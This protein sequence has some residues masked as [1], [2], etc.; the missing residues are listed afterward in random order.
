MTSEVNSEQA[1]WWDAAAQGWVNAQDIV[2]VMLRPFQDLLVQA[3]VERPRD[4][5]LDV[6]CGTGD[7]TRAIAEA[8]GAACVGVDISGTMLAA[9]REHGKAE[10]VQADAQVHRFE[11]S[12]DLIVSRFGVMFFNDPAAA[13]RN[14][15]RAS[16]PGGQLCFIAWRTA[17]E[18]PFM[19]TATQAAAPL[20]P[21]APAPDPDGP[22]PFALADPD[23][24]RKILE[25]AGW[26]GI[27]IQPIDQIR[28]V[29]ESLLVPYLSNLG[30]IARAL[31]EAD[32]SD[33]PR[34]IASVRGAFDGFVHG[35]KVRIPGACWQVTARAL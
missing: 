9:A 23:K 21:D 28:S 10:F 19:T 30:P 4:R 16:A 5:V 18:N 8:T 1:A 24:T 15:L 33:R 3:A 12:F 34:I 35:D 25:Q 13:F 17:D 31:R 2:S 11:E 27:D 32:E 6:G 26:T 20:F 14:L 29:P 22:G 7:V